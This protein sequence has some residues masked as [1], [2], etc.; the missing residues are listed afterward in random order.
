MRRRPLDSR[1]AS[2]LVTCGG[3]AARQ[4]R[5]R[6]RLYGASNDNSEA[7]PID[8]K[9]DIMRLSGGFPTGLWRPTD[10]SVAGAAKP[11]AKSPDKEWMPRKESERVMT[12]NDIENARHGLKGQSSLF[13]AS[14]SDRYRFAWDMSA[15]APLIIKGAGTATGIP[16]NSWT[17]DASFLNRFHHGAMRT[18]HPNALQPNKD[19]PV[20]KK[21]K[22]DDIEDLQMGESGLFKPK[23]PIDESLK[24]LRRLKKNLFPEEV[25]KEEEEIARRKAAAQAAEQARLEEQRNFLKASL[26]GN[27]K[28]P[29]SN[30]TEDGQE[31]CPNCQNVYLDDANFCRQCGEPRKG[32]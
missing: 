12:E 4:P 21:K 5:E 15:G 22:K 18:V 23:Y 14:A 25:K 3:A 31:T 20:R 6:N 13:L 24:T 30:V 29:V 1:E 28:T 8:R 17:S 9:S 11:F 32:R 7:A 27:L 16:W 19:P 2:R 26:S 10:P